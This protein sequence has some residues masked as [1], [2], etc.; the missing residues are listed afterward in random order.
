MATTNPVSL[1]SAPAKLTHLS[2]SRAAVFTTRRRKT[3]QEAG[4][5]LEVLGHA[6]EYLADEF[7]LECMT[8]QKEIAGGVHPRVVAIEILKSCNRQ[9]YLSCPEVPTL[10]E[11]LRSILGFQRA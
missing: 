9:I 8:G 4:R 1:I 3:S 10:G 5:A 7:A 2:Q 11:R 6:I